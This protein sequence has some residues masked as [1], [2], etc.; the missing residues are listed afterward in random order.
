MTAAETVA[1]TLH[2][3]VRNTTG[4]QIVALPERF[5]T[6][7]LPRGT[8]HV[9]AAPEYD[10]TGSARCHPEGRRSMATKTHTDWRTTRS[11][12]VP[13][14]LADEAVLPENHQVK[15]DN[16]SYRPAVGRSSS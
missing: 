10:M 2:F 16:F 9:D 6:V 3:I 7:G 14:S 4:T 8:R 12:V 13:A 11:F 1:G 5:D 15:P